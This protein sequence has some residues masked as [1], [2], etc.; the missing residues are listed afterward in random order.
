MRGGLVIALS[1]ARARP[2][3]LTV[4]GFFDHLWTRLMAPDTVRERG[5]CPVPTVREG[6]SGQTVVEFL[7]EL[8][9]CG[10]DPDIES[11][12]F[13]QRK[14]ADLWVVV[15]NEVVVERQSDSTGGAAGGLPYASN[16]S[17]VDPV[18]HVEVP[19]HKSSI[20]GS[21]DD[22]QETIVGDAPAS[23]VC[24]WRV[25]ERGC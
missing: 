4:G 8:A 16:A 18:H 7:E 24:G 20:K 25:R 3:T 6:A 17:F 23:R 14:V 15:A 1:G 5:V 19:V 2:L 13:C 11:D 21:A 22:L 10:H 12:Q 9:R